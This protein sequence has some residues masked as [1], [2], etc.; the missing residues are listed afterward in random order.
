MDLVTSYCIRRPSP[1]WG[2][3]GRRIYIQEPPLPSCGDRPGQGTFLRRGATWA[4]G[5]VNELEENVLD[6]RQESYLEWL[7]TPPRDRVPSTKKDY[8]EKAGVDKTTLGR[9]EKKEWFIRRWRVAVD[10]AVG[11]PDKLQDVI[12][13]LR[14]EALNG[15]GASMVAAAKLYLQV[16]NQLQPPTQKIEVTRASDLSDEELNSMLAAAAGAELAKRRLADSVGG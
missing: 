5:G 10:E 14:D 4:T 12:E 3:L 1:P 6:A 16:T 2:R 13:K 15:E 9:W 11:S 8:A 7:C